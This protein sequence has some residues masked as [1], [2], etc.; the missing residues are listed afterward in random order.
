MLLGCN[1]VLVIE[2]SVSSKERGHLRAIENWQL[3]HG[4]W[5]VVKVSVQVT[6]AE[7]R[8]CDNWYGD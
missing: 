2:N 4:M 3:D 7:P 5:T 6:E 1:E 8:C